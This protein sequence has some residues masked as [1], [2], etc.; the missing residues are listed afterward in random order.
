MR[1][2]VRND[3]YTLTPTAAPMMT[4]TEK[5]VLSDGRRLHRHRT[6]LTSSRTIGNTMQTTQAYLVAVIPFV[7]AQIAVGGGDTCARF[8]DGSTRCWGSNLDGEVGD[9]SGKEQLR[10]GC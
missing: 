8:T 1:S 3:G 4:M 5:G 6:V 9:G 10:T 7:G 2:C